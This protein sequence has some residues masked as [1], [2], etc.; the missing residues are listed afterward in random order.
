MRK[1]TARPPVWYWQY[2]GKNPKQ[3]A[4]SVLQ[5]DVPPP[6]LYTRCVVR[7][8]LGWKLVIVQ[9]GHTPPPRGL[10]RETPGEERVQMWASRSARKFPGK[11]PDVIEGDSNERQ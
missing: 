10:G 2:I 4:R 7:V 11:Q 1:P 8:L 3:L 9:R 5:T 6:D